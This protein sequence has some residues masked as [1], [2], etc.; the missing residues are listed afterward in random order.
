[1]SE[2]QYILIRELL[3][4]R[5][6]NLRDV[7]VNMLSKSYKVF[8]NGEWLGIT[9]NPTKLETELNEMKTKGTIDQKNVSI[10]PA[11]R[12][13]EI[14]IY[15]E[16]GRIYR[17]I[18][19]VE[20]NVIALKKEYIDNISLNKAEK[21][22]KITDWEE[23]NS[24]YP[25]V[26]DYIDMELQPYLL[27]SDKIRRVEAMRVREVASI[28]KVKNVKSNGTV[29]RYNDMHFLKYTHCEFHPSLLLGEISTNVP[30][31]N[32]N[33]GPRNIFQYAQG[34]QAMGL[35]ATNYRDRLD[36]S[37]I[38]YHPQK[39]LVTTRTAKYVGTE[40]LPSGE[41][42]MVAIACYTGLMISPCRG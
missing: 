2:D 42:V 19:K 12:E 37:Y 21:A 10:V 34:R 30:F 25:G 20:N 35:Y 1:M 4:K 41:N 15:C 7:P 38:L 32:R 18:M 39:P 11:Y 9:D 40:I 14:R 5:I 6:Q 23:F 24:R 27:L 13:G 29:N 22:T 26:I 36:I 16:S 8:L 17:P 28:D 31:A 3:N 33:A